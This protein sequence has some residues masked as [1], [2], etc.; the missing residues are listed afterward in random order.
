MK[1]IRLN[2]IPDEDRKGYSIKRLFTMPLSQRPENVG[3]YE[4]TVPKGSVCKLHKHDQL[5]EIIYFITKAKA[6]LGKEIYS[7]EPGDMI[8][9]SPGDIHEF[10]AEECDL[11]LIAIKLPNNKDDKVVLD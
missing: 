5:D 9:L 10:I 7:F 1:I 3:L 4:T 11:K 6:K 2:E 8:F